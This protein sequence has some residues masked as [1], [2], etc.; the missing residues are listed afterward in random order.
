MASP[1][2]VAKQCA[3]NQ[4]V[5]GMYKA[6]LDGLKANPNLDAEQRDIL[7]GACKGV[8]GKRRHEMQTNPAAAQ[9]LMGICAEIIQLLNNSVIPVIQ[10]TESK[11]F[12]YKLLGDFY[13]YYDEASP[14]TENKDSACKCYQAAADWAA[15]GLAA[16]HPLRLNV[17]LNFGVYYYETMKQQQ[18][19]YEITI[20]A[21]DQAR[22]TLPGLPEQERAQ[23]SFVLCMLTDNA[24]MWCGG[25]G[26]QPPAAVEGLFIPPQQ[27]QPGAPPQ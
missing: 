22:P 16:T 11:V 1:W 15:S 21:I 9:E 3:Q 2:E 12:F 26:Q 6:C 24:K 4:D 5:D 20:A 10:E 14:S 8:S 13:R 7:Y 19:G 17:A 25:L 23:A 18:K 27:G